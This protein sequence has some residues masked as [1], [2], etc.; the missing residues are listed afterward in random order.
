MTKRI[1]KEKE[2]IRI[3]VEVQTIM[4]LYRVKIEDVYFGGKPTTFL[5]NPEALDFLVEVLE[6]VQNN[7]EF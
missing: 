5:L 1:I 4:N 3:T 6:E 2:G 7:K